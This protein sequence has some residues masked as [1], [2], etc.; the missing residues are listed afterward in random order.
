MIDISFKNKR[1]ER[2]F[3]IYDQVTMKYRNESPKLNISFKDEYYSLWYNPIKRQI[4]FE[5]NR[6]R[7]P[8]HQNTKYASLKDVLNKELFF[9]FHAWLGKGEKKFYVERLILRTPKNQIMRIQNL[10]K[11]PNSTIEFWT[12]LD[13]ETIWQ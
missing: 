7:L 3:T 8:A 12:I 11:L 6:L 2:I 4:A 9:R 1:G 10:E 5:A 13:K